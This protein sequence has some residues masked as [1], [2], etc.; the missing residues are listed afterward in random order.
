MTL[1][2]SLAGTILVVTSL[3]FLIFITD[4][5][6]EGGPLLQRNPFSWIIFWPFIFFTN[7]DLWVLFGAL[8]FNALLCFLAIFITIQSGIPNERLCD[9][10]AGAR[11][12]VLL[13]ASGVGAIGGFCMQRI[14]YALAIRTVFRV[15][16]FA[17]VLIA[18]VGFVLALS[19]TSRQVSDLA[20]SA[21][22]IL[23][24][25]FYVAYLVIG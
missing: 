4:V 23:I 1:L 2:K 6:S 11:I 20:L 13:S 22:A 14:E 3:L 18:I 5:N 19:P 24:A 25:C 17:S 16:W 10:W 8:G 12:P 21:A 9:R 7:P 15:V